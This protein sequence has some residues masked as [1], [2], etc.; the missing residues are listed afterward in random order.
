MKE[1]SPG[2]FI[3]KE[4]GVIKLRKPPVNIYIIV[5]DSHGLIFDAGYGDKKTVKSVIKEIEE[6]KALCQSQNK[7]F[8]LTHILPSHTHPDHISGLYKLSKSLGLKVILTK[9]MAEIIKNKKSYRSAREADLLKDLFLIKNFW[10]HA[11]SKINDFFHWFFYKYAFGIK[12]I[13]N[14]D[15]IIEEDTEI[16][17][18]NES[19]K[20]IASPGHAIDH[21]SLYNKEK[22]ILLSGDNVIK[23]VTTWI[24]PPGSNIESYVNSL[25]MIKNLPNLKFLLAAHGRP[26]KNPIRRVEEIIVHRKERTK[27]VIEIVTKYPEQGITPKELINELYPQ[28][29]KIIQRIG[30]GWVCL[31]LKMLEEQSLVTHIREKKQIKFYPTNKL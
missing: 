1:V 3:I 13:E 2:I 27:Q 30:R 7:E 17:I 11:I 25:E 6:I 5:G 14:P 21:I 24:G 19:W 9:K 31:T 29:A 20:I 16:S 15:E 10:G 4:K 12:F 8:K 22:G 23:N 26:I 28:G 18:N